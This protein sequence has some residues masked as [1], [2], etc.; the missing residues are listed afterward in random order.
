MKRNLL[1]KF[2]KKQV[3]TLKCHYGNLQYEFEI[4]VDSENPLTFKNILD[5]FGSKYFEKE[6]TF[7]DFEIQKD[8]KINLNDKV[9]DHD[10]EQVYKILDFELN[11]KTL[12]DRS[13]WDFKRVHDFPYFYLYRDYSP[14]MID[15]I[16]PNISTFMM[17]DLKKK[18]YN[19]ESNYFNFL[20]KRYPEHTFNIDILNK[21]TK[22]PVDIEPEIVKHGN[23]SRINITNKNQIK[24]L[25]IQ[26][27]YPFIEM[28]KTKGEEYLIDINYKLSGIDTNEY[29]A[30]LVLK[31]TKN[32]IYIPIS[33][34][35]AYNYEEESSKEGM[36]K[37]LSPSNKHWKTHYD[38]SIQE[39]FERESFPN[40]NLL[41][42]ISKHRFNT[43]RRS[44]FGID[45]DNDRVRFN[46]YTRP[47]VDE[48]E[49]DE[50]L[51]RSQY[52]DFN[53]SN[54]FT[55]QNMDE[56]KKFMTILNI[57]TSVDNHK[58]SALYDYHT[59]Q[60]ITNIDANNLSRADIMEVPRASDKAAEYYEDII[61]KLK[62]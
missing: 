32:H 20:E 45:V 4:Q 56:Y 41:K 55:I 29:I 48:R 34:I 17:K 8:A 38:I 15:R 60:N 40:Y 54:D 42:V 6:K 19:Y 7:K 26:L 33:F 13:G 59:L 57:L 30:E 58:L 9:E 47:R 27:L 18:V 28:K 22:L 31:N 25:Y 5:D 61:A 35:K 3:K 50:S 21:Y 52:L 39:H 14:S 1:N 16:L 2:A 11:D 53:F 44:Q 23:N 62:H 24:Q 49:I 36:L 46:V 12:K 51:G 37:T 10:L 43:R